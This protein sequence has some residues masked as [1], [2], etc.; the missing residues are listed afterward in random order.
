MLLCKFI[1]RVKKL[2]VDAYIVVYDV[3]NSNKYII[4]RYVTHCNVAR[5]YMSVMAETDSDKI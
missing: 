3:G 1:I 5:R 2:K 4:D